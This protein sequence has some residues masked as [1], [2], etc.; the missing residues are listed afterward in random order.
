MPLTKTQ[1][2]YFRK[3]LVKELRQVEKL[4]ANESRPEKK[5]YYYSAAYGITSRTLRYSFSRDILLADFVLNATYGLLMDR[6]KHMKQGDL[7]ILLED[8]HFEKLC[9]GLRLLAD[10]LEAE[11][12]I[13]DVLELIFTTAFST[14][15]PGNYI[16][17]KGDL[18]F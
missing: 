10:R 6:L 7:T 14:T 18:Q 2:K 5:L 12:N 11:D 15:G 8:T 16:R 9:E 13:Q 4:V 17:E 1:Q 3:E